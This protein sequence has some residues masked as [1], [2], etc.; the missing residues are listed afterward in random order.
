[1]SFGRGYNQSAGD[2]FHYVKFYETHY[3]TEDLINITIVR[4]EMNLLFTKTLKEIMI[5]ILINLIY[6]YRMEGLLF[7][8]G[9]P[10]SDVSNTD[11]TLV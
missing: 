6:D 4:N 10:G 7:G 1:M 2:E 5:K 3:D 11:T 8:S 9:D